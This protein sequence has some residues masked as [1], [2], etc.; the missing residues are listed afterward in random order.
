MQNHWTKDDVAAAWQR[1]ERTYTHD[2]VGYRFLCGH[3]IQDETDEDA[4]DYNIIGVWLVCHRKYRDWSSEKSYDLAWILE[5]MQA[6]HMTIP[7]YI[8]RTKFYRKK[9][10]LMRYSY[11]KRRNFVDD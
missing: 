6:Y 3:C 8:K 2:P 5:F 4:L 11:V 10:K 9:M 1:F 7:R